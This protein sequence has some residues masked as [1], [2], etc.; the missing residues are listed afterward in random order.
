MMKEKCGEQTRKTRDC[1]KYASSSAHAAV[2]EPVK[3]ES[4]KAAKLRTGSHGK[5]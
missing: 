5:A 1:V 4:F 2:V 3:H